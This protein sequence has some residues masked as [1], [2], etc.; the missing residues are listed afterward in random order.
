MFC[1]KTPLF[2]VKLLKW[3]ELWPIW[4]CA[5]GCRFEEIAVEIFDIYP[6]FGKT[7]YF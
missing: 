6:V 3:L 1:G 7:I 5:A 2:R 4:L